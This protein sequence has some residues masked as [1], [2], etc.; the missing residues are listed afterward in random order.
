MIT[1]IFKM[2]FKC[3]SFI[4]G[5]DITIAVLFLLLCMNV[6]TLHVFLVCWL[7][8]KITKH[9]SPRLRLYCLMT[10]PSWSASPGRTF[11]GDIRN[12]K[13]NSDSSGSTGAREEWFIFW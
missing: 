6:F 11:F 1:L 3:I 9:D 12:M 10:Y 2:T 7:F 13:K 4:F 5:A 8:C